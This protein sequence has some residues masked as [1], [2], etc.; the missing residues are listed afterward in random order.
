MLKLTPKM[1]TLPCGR[2]FMSD[3]TFE[4][5]EHLESPRQP[6]EEVDRLRRGLKAWCATSD[7]RY[8]SAKDEDCKETV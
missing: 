5:S 2:V 6:E 7:D 3:P 8:D 1:E 4:V